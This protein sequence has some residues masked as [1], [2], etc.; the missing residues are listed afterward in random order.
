MSTDH[1]PFEPGRDDGHWAAGEG[2]VPP[3]TAG[4]PASW[5][6]RVVAIFVDWLVVSVPLAFVL[7]GTGL[8]DISSD[9]GTIQAGTSG[10]GM[11]ISA[12]VPIGY[13][14]VLEGSPRGQ[15]VGKMAIR[16]RV[17]DGTTGGPIGPGRAAMRR[18][19]YV[20]LLWI[21]FVPGV[22]NGLSPLWDRR[23]QAWHDKAV[24]SL[25]VKV[26]R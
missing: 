6:Q 23:R 13:S 26:G 3:G 2:M 10:L 11:L 7:V 9:R 25:V 22:L 20:A 21:C 14:A 12:L 19:V 4:E 15:S 24:N 18:V 5:W 1:D 17:A 16:I 8:V